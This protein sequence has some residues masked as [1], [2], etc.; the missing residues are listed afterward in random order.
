MPQTAINS[1]TT[2]KM[3]DKHIQA[4]SFTPPLHTLPEDVR[5]SINQLLETFKSQF[6]KDETSIGTTYLTKMQTDTG[7]SEPVLQKPYLIAMKH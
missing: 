6:A 3:I 4:N 2:Q 1:L 7:D 5:K